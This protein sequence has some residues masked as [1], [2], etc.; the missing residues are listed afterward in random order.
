MTLYIWL[1]FIYEV[2]GNLQTEFARRAMSQPVYA[3]SALE[4]KLW[5]DNSIIS[6][7]SLVFLF[8]VRMNGIAFL[9]YLGFKTV[10]W[11]PIVIWVGCLVGTGVAA[12]MFNGRTGLAIPGM[13]GFVVLPIIAVSLWFTI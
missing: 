5:K 2:F 4:R 13:L 7:A 8:S 9:V 10:W 1:I 12:S 3:L 11:H 6:L